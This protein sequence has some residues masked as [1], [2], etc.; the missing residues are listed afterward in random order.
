MA[1]EIIF[2]SQVCIIVIFS[3]RTL[4]ISCKDTFE[5]CWKCMGDLLVWLNEQNLDKSLIVDIGMPVMHK[6]LRYN[7]RVVLFGGRIQLIRPKMILA[8]GGMYR[9]SRWFVPWMRNR[10]IVQYRLPAPIIAITGQE[11]VPFGDAILETIDGVRIGFE[12]C[13]ELFALEA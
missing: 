13:E 11:T 9:E 1:A 4:I 5:H 12:I 6:N 7:C 3:W 10:Q 8:D 2:L